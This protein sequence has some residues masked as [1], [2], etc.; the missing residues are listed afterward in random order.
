MSKALDCEILEKAVR[1]NWIVVTLDADFHSILALSGNSAPSVVRIREEG[2]KGDSIAR[3]LNAI[4]KV[5]E[6][7]LTEGCVI[8]YAEGNLRLRML[9]ITRH[10]E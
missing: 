6:T 4:A 10:R 2:L 3:I 8:S 7:P 1:E 5:A 9:P